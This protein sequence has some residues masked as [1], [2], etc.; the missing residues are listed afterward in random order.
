M[1]ILQTNYN[2][3]TRQFMH[4]VDVK[5]NNVEFFQI[6][7]IPL[8]I[9]DIAYAHYTHRDVKFDKV[10]LIL[11]NLMKMIKFYQISKIHFF[12][13]RLSLCTHT[14]ELLIILLI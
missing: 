4:T 14:Q 5:F 7:I 8:L 11:S 13:A 1:A 12:D 6:S 3:D 2:F 10:Y 9:R